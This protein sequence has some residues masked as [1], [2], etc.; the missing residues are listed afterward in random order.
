MSALIAVVINFIANFFVRLFFEIVDK[1]PEVVAS[2]SI[3]KLLQSD[4]IKVTSHYLVDPTC[5]DQGLDLSEQRL[6]ISSA[7]GSYFSGLL[8][9]DN[10]YVSLKDQITVKYSSY[11]A[12]KDPY[13]LIYLALQHPK[14]PRILVVAAEGGMGK[15]TLITKIIRCLYSENAIDLILGDSAKTLEVDPISGK[16]LN[17]KHEFYDLDSFLLKLCSQLGLKYQIKRSNQQKSISKIKD[18]LEGRRSLIVIDNL[19]TINNGSDFLNS[20]RMLANRDTRILV[21]TR[22]IAGVTGNTPGILFVNLQPLTDETAVREFLF[23]HI[24]NHANS[25][26]KIMELKKDLSNN[27]KINLLIKRTGGIPLLLQLVVN[28]ISR[29]SWEIL[30]TM[31]NIFGKDLLDFLYSERWKELSQLGENGQ[32]AQ[33]LLV[34]ISKQMYKGKISFK[35]LQ[36]WAK[37]ND[38]VFLEQ[39]ISLLEERFMLINTDRKVGNFSVFPS[40]AEFIENC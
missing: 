9:K 11:E 32:K 30:N 22:T 2:K 26:P 8:E 37:C 33:E 10:N 5:G 20:L 34:Y 18:R 25:Q 36:A 4:K 38:Y 3:D 19:E 35:D 29:S 39:I 15:S 16:I 28:D 12:V 17:V 14:G 27:K 13:Q 24:K 7:F 23:W 1:I 21:T 6:K 31:P 40:L